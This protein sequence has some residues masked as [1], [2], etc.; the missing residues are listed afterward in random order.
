MIAEYSTAYKDA[1]MTLSA[2]F[3]ASPA[4]LHRVP[5]EYHAALIE[6]LET[7]RERAEAF[8]ILSG[9]DIAGY[10]LTAKTF[11][12]EA[13]GAVWWL[14]ELYIRPEYRSKGL[15]GEYFSYIEQKAKTAG[16]KRLRL[17]VEPANVRAGALYRRLGYEKFAYEQMIKD[18]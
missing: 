10:A 9:G 18:L 11:S 14:E 13:G 5:D 6:E 1:L 4:V 12:H 2:E 7:S 16:V 3:Y 17:E 15:G 8:I